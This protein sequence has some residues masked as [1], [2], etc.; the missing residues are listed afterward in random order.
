LAEKVLMVDDMASDLT[1]AF[2]LTM[3]LF[4]TRVAPL[5]LMTGAGEA[6]F[7]EGAAIARGSRANKVVVRMMDEFVEVNEGLLDVVNADNRRKN[8]L[9][10]AKKLCECQRVM[11]VVVSKSINTGEPTRLHILFKAHG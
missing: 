8:G 3:Y 9:E 2:I 1:P 7:V 6:L 4:S 11:P 5:G 10:W